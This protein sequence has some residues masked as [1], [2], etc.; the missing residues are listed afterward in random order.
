MVKVDQIWADNGS[1]EMKAFQ[2][3]PCWVPCGQVWLEIHLQI[4]QEEREYFKLCMEWGR[5]RFLL[6]VSL[7]A[8]QSPITREVYCQRS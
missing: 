1:K 3:N 8:I 7:S 2:P 6:F 4:S 5:T